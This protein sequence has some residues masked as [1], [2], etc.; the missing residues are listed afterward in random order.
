MCVVYMIIILCIGLG[1]SSILAAVA[2]AAVARVFGRQYAAGAALF[3]SGRG[4]RA[5]A[6]VAAVVAAAAVAAAAAAAAAAG[7]LYLP[8]VL[9]PL[10]KFATNQ[11]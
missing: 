2:T 8:S 5:A 11:P 6:R 1:V 3:C 7:S 4:R 10:C 9:E